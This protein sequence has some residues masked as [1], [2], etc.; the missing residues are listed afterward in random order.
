[1]AASEF[2]K[3]IEIYLTH[4]EG[5]LLLKDIWEH[6][7]KLQKKNTNIWLIENVCI[8]KLEFNKCSNTYH[9]SNTYHNR[10]LRQEHI[11]TLILK[12]MIKILNLKFVATQEYLNVRIFCK[13]LQLVRNFFCD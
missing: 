7:Q 10:T 6:L 9:R 8:D 12:T 11:L 4:N 5:L 2:W 3:Y 13:R 1:M